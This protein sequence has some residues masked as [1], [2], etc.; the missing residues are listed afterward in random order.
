MP[1][2]TTS[3]STPASATARRASS[4]LWATGSSAIARRL[5]CWTSRTACFA[6]RAPTSTTSCPGCGPS[7]AKTSNSHSVPRGGG[8]TASR[9]SSAQKSPQSCSTEV[10]DTA[11]HRRQRDH[12][13]ARLH[14]SVEPVECAHVLALD[15]DVRER[16][17]LLERREPAHE[18][19]EQVADGVALGREL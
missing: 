18:V 10:L 11:G 5:C 14:F 9:S 7:S 3:T 2:C 19:V 12:G 1:A 17:L 16:Q 6:S 15:V 8:A 4:T 13:R